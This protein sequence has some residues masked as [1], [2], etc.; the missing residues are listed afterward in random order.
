MSAVIVIDD[1]EDSRAHI[2][3]VLAGAGHD[4]L[5]TYAD[6]LSALVG[7]TTAGAVRPDVI[8]LDLE[9]PQIDG[10][11]FLAAIA[12]HS[13]LSTIPIVL[14]SSSPDPDPLAG[15]FVILEKPLE[16]DDLRDAVTAG[17]LRA[18]RADAA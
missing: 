2:A 18:T 10:A 3:R 7:L 17:A 15:V 4:V 13:S 14:V 16:V 11:S 1:E 5:A 9:M 6:A 8:V 12:D